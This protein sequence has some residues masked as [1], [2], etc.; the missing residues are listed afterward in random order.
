MKKLFRKLIFPIIWKAIIKGVSA[1]DNLYTYP[2][3]THLELI[4]KDSIRE[5]YIN[6]G[7]M[8]NIL[9]VEMNK[10]F[11]T[12][13]REKYKTITRHEMLN[14]MTNDELNMYYARVEHWKNHLMFSKL[15]KLELKTRPK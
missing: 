4:V 10:F 14:S 1:K 9:V 13:K 7:D 3:I 11:N 2:F 15:D 6:N 5:K 12:M 8:H